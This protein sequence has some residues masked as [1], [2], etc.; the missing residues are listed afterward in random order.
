MKTTLL[1]AAAIAAATFSPKRA[2][3]Q[4]V[5]GNF[6]TNAVTKTGDDP[7]VASTWFAAALGE[8]PA[9]DSGKWQVIIFDCPNCPPCQK[10]VEDFKSHPALKALAQEGKD[11][12]AQLTI[13][14][15]GNKGQKFRFEQWD[16]TET[17]V[18]TITPPPNSRT[19][20]YYAVSRHTGY[21]GKPEELARTLI[22][23]ISLYTRRF[24]PAQPKAEEQLPESRRNRDTT[25]DRGQDDPAARPAP[26]QGR[27]ANH[28][29]PV[30]AARLPANPDTADRQ[31]QAQ[32]RP[33]QTDRGDQDHARRRGP[34]PPHRLEGPHQ[35][36]REA[37]SLAI[38]Q[39]ITAIN[40]DYGLQWTT[41]VVA[42]KD[43]PKDSG[44]RERTHP[45]CSS[46]TT[47]AS[48]YN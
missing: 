2:D 39:R 40:K 44:L 12:W 13:Y 7:T 5:V 1:L 34:Q 43:L 11:G 48:S 4:G 17:P 19:W 36:P 41:T 42:W 38:S 6:T 3:A 21:D 35:P 25:P 14:N 46:N 47:A 45:P 32:A 8:I 23:E 37:G 28:P 15:S 18:L 20:P 31:R 16:V 27:P 33:R 24:G 30:Q 29:R 22:T 10:L 26:T 9:D